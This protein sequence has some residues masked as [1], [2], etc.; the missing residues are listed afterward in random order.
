MTFII[1]LSLILKTL[2]K[3]KNRKIQI[4]RMLQSFFF[5]LF[6]HLCILLVLACLIFIV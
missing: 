1:Q 5:S 2:A 4:K 6:P 3:K